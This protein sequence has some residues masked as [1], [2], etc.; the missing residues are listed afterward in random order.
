MRRGKRGTGRCVLVARRGD[1]VTKCCCQQF[2]W[3]AHA[4]PP[5]G[6]QNPS[7]YRQW[8]A[9]SVMPSPFMLFIPPTS[10][11]VAIA[12]YGDAISDTETQSLS[13]MAIFCNMRH[14][15][16][17]WEASSTSVFSSRCSFI[18]PWRLCV[19]H[20]WGVVQRRDTPRLQTQPATRP[21]LIIMSKRWKHQL[22]EMENKATHLAVAW[23][24]PAWI[25]N[26]YLERNIS[27][28]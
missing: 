21:A 19:N 2:H 6:D 12:C 10:L 20:L 11:V 7:Y 17:Y 18:Q 28:S 8:V 3:T 27:L 14:F 13:V 5:A 24:L 1:H 16:G 26:N 4:W 15:P 22:L 23:Q 25:C 9:V